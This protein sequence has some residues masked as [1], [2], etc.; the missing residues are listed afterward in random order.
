MRT[1]LVIWKACIARENNVNTIPASPVHQSGALELL[2]NR[3]VSPP[4]HVWNLRN[5]Y[6]DHVV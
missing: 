2:I 6:P 5:A 3:E 1:S 4:R